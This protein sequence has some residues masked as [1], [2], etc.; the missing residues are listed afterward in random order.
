[1]LKIIDNSVSNDFFHRFEVSTVDEGAGRLRLPS[2]GASAM[3]VKLSY[4]QLIEDVRC[5]D[6]S[7]QNLNILQGSSIPCILKLSIPDRC[8]PTQTANR[9]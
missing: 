9:R 7:S 8:V 4:R 3:K 2:L 5:R 1:M 6:E